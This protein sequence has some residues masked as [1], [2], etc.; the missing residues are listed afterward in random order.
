[1]EIRLRFLAWCFAADWQWFHPIQQRKVQRVARSVAVHHSLRKIRNCCRKN[2]SWRCLVDTRQAIASP[3]THK[4]PA[5]FRV[6]GTGSFHQTLQWVDFRGLD[7]FD[8]LLDG[9]INYSLVRIFPVKRL[10]RKRQYRARRSY[11]YRLT[12]N[13]PVPTFPDGHQRSP[14]PQ[15]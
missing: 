9:S 6:F 15:R 3:P 2:S 10:N 13:W 5:R 11:T 7:W 1:M 4:E 14:V 8:I 12:P